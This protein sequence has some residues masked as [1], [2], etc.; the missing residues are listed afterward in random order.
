MAYSEEFVAGHS[1]WS[2]LYPHRKAVPDEAECKRLMLSLVKV[3]QAL[4]VN[5]YIHR[6]IKPQNIIKTDVPERPFVVLDLGIAFS[7]RETTITFNPQNRAPMTY[8]YMAPEMGNPDFRATLDYRA[9]L[10]SSAL[11]VY[12]YAAGVHPLASRFDDTVKTVSRAMNEIPKP[13]QEHRTEFEPEFCA[14]I[15]TML[16]KKPALR[17]GNISMILRQLEV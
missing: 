15:D 17:H 9:D 4:W 3:I 12:E 16:K 1:L 2:L 5:G 8:R 10:Y 11:T 7:L 14:L 13:L 6:D